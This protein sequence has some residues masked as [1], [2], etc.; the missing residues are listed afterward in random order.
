MGRQGGVMIQQLL[1]RLWRRSFHRAFQSPHEIAHLG[2]L[3]SLARSGPAAWLMAQEKARLDYLAAKDSFAQTGRSDAFALLL[4]RLLQLQST[5]A[6]V[7]A[8]LNEHHLERLLSEEK[9]A[10]PA[11]E[12]NIG[13]SR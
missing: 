5:S 11:G 3:E 1:F 2:A 10:V 6:V 4:E 13:K 9:P 8:L 12:F 7:Q